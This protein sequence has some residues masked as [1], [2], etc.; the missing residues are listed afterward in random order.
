M[1]SAGKMDRTFLVAMEMTMIAISITS[2]ASDAWAL[3][4]PP[5]VWN[6]N[7]LTYDSGSAPA[8]AISGTVIV[9]VHEGASGALWY[10]TGKIQENG[11]VTWAAAP[12]QYDNG[13]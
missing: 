10:H 13:Y 11:K 6:G 5:L 4:T 2:A 9:E 3:S 1:K 12:A 7:S 8:V